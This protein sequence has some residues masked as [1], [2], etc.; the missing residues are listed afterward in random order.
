[1]GLQK[2]TA[3]QKWRVF[4]F[5]ETDNTAVTGDAANISA[6]IAKDW[7]AATAT[8]D[9]APTEV[10]DGYYLFDLTQAETNADNLD[11][12]PESS[13]ANIQVI[14]V[15]GTQTTVPSGFSDDAMRGTDSAATAAALATVDTV[16]DAIKA[17][18]DDLTFTTANQVDANIQSVNDVAVT[19]TGAEGD[20]WGP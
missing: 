12:Y 4:A 11:L 1:M 16:V 15:P 14:G 18:T 10:E 20:E 2:N 17:K 19:G 7:G 13:T 3:S 5:N 9:V 8:N 6:K